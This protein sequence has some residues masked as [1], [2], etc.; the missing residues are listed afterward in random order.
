MEPWVQK[1]LEYDPNWYSGH[2]NQ[3]MCAFVLRRDLPVVW[4]C[5]EKCKK[6]PDTIWRY[7]TAFLYAYEGDL[8]KAYKE[9]KRAFYDP[10]QDATI[11]LQCEDFI[12]IVLETEPEKG[13]L[14]YCLGLINLRAKG[15]LLAAKNDFQQFLNSE[16]A[17]LFPKEQKLVRIWIG[18]IQKQLKEEDAG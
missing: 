1:A 17:A 18:E 9:Y 8:G 13:Q 4:E 16:A 15:D 11:P 6:I 3:A 2:L 7:S 12:H 5:M 10:P 14:Y